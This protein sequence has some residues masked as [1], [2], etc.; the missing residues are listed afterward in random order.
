[1]HEAKGS[2]GM[3][4]QSKGA[5][6]NGRG[7]G[8]A[9]HA[10]P[11]LP[12]GLPP[13]VGET[14]RAAYADDHLSA[15]DLLL[16]GDEHDAAPIASGDEV[17]PDEEEVI[18][19]R[20]DATFPCEKCGADLRFTPG[21]QTLRCEYC[22]HTNDIPA[23]GEQVGELDFNDYLDRLEQQTEVETQRV[24]KCNT[25]GAEPELGEGV[26]ASECPFCG[27]A[28]VTQSTSRRLIKPGSLLPFLVE[29]RHGRELFR[30]WLKS[31]WF[32]PNTLKKAATID[33][34]LK[35]V[36][37]PHWTFD[38]ATITYYKGKRGTH[39]TRGTG[40]NRRTYTSWRRVS[41]VVTHR[42][43]DVLVRASGSLPEKQ[44]NELEPWDLQNLTPYDDAYLAGFTAEAYTTDLRGGFGVATLIMDKHL[45]RLVKRDIGGDEQRI[46]SMKTQHRGV[47]F[48]HILLPVWVSAYRYNDKTYRFLVNGRTGEVQG[49]RPYS[50]WKITL[51]VLAGL[52]VIGVI[53]WIIN[54]SGLVSSGGGASF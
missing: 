24:V 17:E 37:V 5:G 49:E 48:K 23:S 33:Q 9:T 51:A 29:R 16:A 10:A 11:P 26:T 32:A 53:F 14:R 8:G 2:I 31:L 20:A 6:P 40:K 4:S 52:V 30:K 34:R 15:R 7:G 50:F 47:T 19:P 39:R 41:G 43:D 45:R 44:A 35:G 28:I 13:Q 22:G 54:G 12:P 21:L 36:Y 46:D 3:A 27:S 1:L 18:A 25:C 38:S 42:F